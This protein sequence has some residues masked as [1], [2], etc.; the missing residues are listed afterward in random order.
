LPYRPEFLEKI[1][2]RRADLRAQLAALLPEPRPIVWEIGCGHGHFL[3]R[4]AEAFP[5]KYCLGVD[6]LPERLERG[7]RKRDRAGL[8]NC[9]FV[10]AE[11]RE[12]LHALPAGMTLAEV[13]VLFP[14]PWPK[15][16]HNKNRLL[17]PEFFE[18]I[19][20]RAGEGARFHFRT[21]HAE[22]FHEVA[23]FFA[24]GAIPTWRFDPAAPWPLEHATV[25]QAKA[26]AY[27]SLIAVR[28]SHPARPVAPV[29]P[30]LPPPGDP[31]SPA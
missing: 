27:H 6:I 18:A 2:R 22:Y 25:F 19:A 4:Y 17:K 14:D 31:T 11:A 8:A 1:A 12:C 5:E 21:D 15:A 10:R 29:A 13:W 9:Q 3:V 28:T 7:E 16:R 30:G 26:P 23:A 20:A 24:D